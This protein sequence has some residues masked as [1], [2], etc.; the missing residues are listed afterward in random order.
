MTTK[1]AKRAHVSDDNDVQV[2]S[3]LA[4]KAKSKQAKREIAPSSDDPRV[5]LRRLVHQHKAL[6]MRAVAVENMSIDKKRRDTGEVIACPLPKDVAEEFQRVADDARKCAQQL[7]PAIMKQLKMCD[8]FNA[9]LSKV[10]GCASGVVPA[11]LVAMIDIRKTDEAGRELKPSG[12]RR[13][14]GL[15]VNPETGKSDRP[16]P[17]HKLQYNKE[18]KCRLWQ[19]F[20]A[21]RKNA[22]K[23]TKTAPLGITNKYLDIWY[24]AKHGALHAGMKPG[25]ADAKGRRKA[26]DVFILDL[27]TMWRALEGLEVWPSYYEHRIGPGHRGWHLL[28]GDKLRPKRLTPEAAALLVG[29]LSTRPLAVKREWSIDIEAEE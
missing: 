23:A 28:E 20:Q 9:Y 22:A 1:D 2:A 17:G 3:K 8:V 19:M 27:Y 21:M 6:V 24:N 15:G 12:L 4:R 7:E 13:Y 29:D 5:E 10:Y 16:T 25:A 18:L 11:Y 26:A 14:C